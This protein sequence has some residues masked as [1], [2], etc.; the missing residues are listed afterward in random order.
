MGEEG[1]EESRS[2]LVGKWRIMSSEVVSGKH[3]N[4]VLHIHI[5]S[6]GHRHQGLGFPAHS[7]KLFRVS[8][9]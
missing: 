5:W 4:R 8:S 1:W 7:A 6:V 9:S 3:Q 2:K